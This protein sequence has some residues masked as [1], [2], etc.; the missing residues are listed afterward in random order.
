[1]P[2]WDSGLVQIV[3]ADFPADGD[4]LTLLLWQIAALTA[5]V[6]TAGDLVPLSRELDRLMSRLQTRRGHSEPDA[7]DDLEQRRRRKALHAGL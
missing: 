1:V 7:L 4:P 6:T 3:K 5:G 2:D